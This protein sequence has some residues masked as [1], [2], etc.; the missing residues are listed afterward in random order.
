MRLITLILRFGRFEFCWPQ[1]ICAAT[2][3]LSKGDL[4]PFLHSLIRNMSNFHALAG[5]GAGL[6]SAICTLP[7]VISTLQHK[8]KPH[9]VTW[10]VLCTLE[11]V[12][13]VNQLSA[14][15][16]STIWLPLSA[17]IG[18]FILALLSIRYGEGRWSK[19]DVGLI[20]A[21]LFSFVILTQF[22]SPLLALAWTISID[23][24][25]FLPTLHKAR[26][27]PET[28]SLSSWVLNFAGTCL[29]L[30]AVE[31]WSTSAAIL[32]IYLFLGT[33]GVVFFLLMP[34]LRVLQPKPRLRRQIEQRLPRPISMGLF[35]CRR[36]YNAA[37]KSI[38]STPVYFWLYHYLIE[39]HY[40]FHYYGTRSTYRAYNKHRGYRLSDPLVTKPIAPIQN[41]LRRSGR[42]QVTQPEYNHSIEW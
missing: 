4:P 7:Y 11:F 5:M 1:F 24:L 22:H 38:H 2:V 36:L 42:F 12:M 10:W 21:A 25:G 23:F 34:Y 13:L 17:A 18:H 40:D 3:A 8:T 35:A 39:E 15:G 30:F 14:G 9:R 20:A 28:E 37:W 29:N 19:F 27:A 6:L 32:P 33:G 41:R 31:Q 26:R 16:G